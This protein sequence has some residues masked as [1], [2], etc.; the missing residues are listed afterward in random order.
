MKTNFI[1]KHKILT[2]VII[3]LI[4]IAGYA[5]YYLTSYLPASDLAVESMITTQKVT[6]TETKDTITFK[7]T[8]SDTK[9][10]L[11]YYPGG[12][13]DPVSFAYAANQIANEDIFVVIQKMPFNLAIFGID[14]ANKI[15]E[16]Y[17][18]IDQWYLAGFSLGGTAASMYAHANPDKVAG[19]ILYASYTTKDANLRDVSFPVLSISGSNDGLATPQDILD[20][21][22]YLPATTN[23]IKIEGANHTQM[24]LYNDAK[25]Q[26]GDNPA[27]ITDNQ[28]QQDIIDATIKFIETT[29]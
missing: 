29:K 9:V 17:P 20:K 25:P 26:S 4:L 22:M 23:F 8:N 24:A 1:K 19:L 14:K 3:A 10:G 6:V 21:S 28:Q 27:D 11:I 15:M 2:A 13:V 5:T 12:K 7:P 18:E 16:T